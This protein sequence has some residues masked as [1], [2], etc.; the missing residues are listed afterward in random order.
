VAT[1]FPVIY[2]RGFAGATSGIDRAVDDPF[3]GFNAGATH[4]RVGSDAEPAFY[5]FEGPMVRLMSE[6]GYEILVHGNQE[7]FLKASPDGSL[8]PRSVWI[9]RFYDSAADTFGHEGRPY[10]LLTAAKGLFDFTRLVQKKTDAQ[11]VWLVAHSMG[12]LICRSMLQKVCPDRGVAA[13]SLVDKLFT[14]ATPHGGIAFSIAGINLAVPEIAPFGAEIFNAENMYGYLT[15]DADRTADGKPPPGDDNGN[16]AWNPRDIPDLVLSHDRVFCLI[17]TNAADYGLVSRAVG[18]KSDGLVQIDN[19]YV[20]GAHRAFVHRSHSGAYGEVNSEEGYQNLRR[21]LFGSWKVAVELCGLK[22]PDPPPGQD[23]DIIDVWQAEVR[24]SIRGLPVV[25]TEQLA[26][27]YCPIQLNM[28]AARL[29]DSPDSPVPLTTVFLLNPAHDAG[30]RNDLGQEM[31]PRCRCTLQLRALHLQER[32]GAFFW[33]HHLETAAD[34]DDTLIVDL[35][36]ADDDPH[37]P[38]LLWATWN[39]LIPAVTS[40]RDPITPE[41]IAPVARRNSDPDNAI[42]FTIDMPPAGQAILGTTPSHLRLT[43]VPWT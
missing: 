3:Y 1:P 34:W 21:F 22:L 13:A 37:G 26:A 5:Q 4:V 38:T 27:H 29:P 32:H 43:A 33:Q 40:A 17:G 8:G 11:K 14:Y 28:E 18:P 25:I 42:A 36:P 30:R 20:R 39:S 7:A 23:Q 15:P 31:S 16:A 41:P 19:A 9:Y 35:G 2:V 10:D 12:G 24:L 6:E